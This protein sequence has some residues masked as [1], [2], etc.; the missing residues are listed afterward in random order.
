VEGFSFFLTAAPFLGINAP[1][2]FFLFLA[3]ATLVASTTGFF[4]LDDA[5]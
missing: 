4:E 3:A 5:T 2:A 1:V